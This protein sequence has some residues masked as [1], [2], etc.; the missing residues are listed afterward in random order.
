MWIAKPISALSEGEKSLWRFAH[1]SVR[2]PL[3]Q[4]LSWAAASELGTDGSFVVFQPTEGVGGVVFRWRS[5][6]GKYQYECVNGPLL[7]WDSKDQAPRQLATF[8]QAVTQ[9]GNFESL[10]IRPRWETQTLESRLENLPV[11]PFQTDLAATIQIQLS[12]ARPQERLSRAALRAEKAGASLERMP[13]VPGPELTA[14]AGR[15]QSFARAN[16][17]ST[18]PAEW[19]EKWI[20]AM[21]PED[22]LKLEHVRVAV[23]G[24]RTSEILA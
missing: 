7:D 24:G 23:P 21:A 9:L 13:L 1:R 22:Q 19:F 5:A 20:R 10:T 16:G 4:T 11:E 15:L 2:G 17:F 6:S 3:S 12:E 18:P 14:L 8:A